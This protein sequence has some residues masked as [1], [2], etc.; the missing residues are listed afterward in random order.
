MAKLS[1]QS[2]KGLRMRQMLGRT[3]LRL[4]RTEWADDPRAEEVKP[5]YEAQLQDINDELQR[6]RQARREALGEELPE[7]PTVQMKPVTL[8][9]QAQ[10]PE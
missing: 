8:G 1:D 6:R 2:V 9:A 7:G 5:Q 4:L 10:E 3:V